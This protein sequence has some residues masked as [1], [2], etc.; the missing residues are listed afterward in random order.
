MSQKFSVSILMASWLGSLGLAHAASFEVIHSFNGPDG[1]FPIST[2]IF[3]DSGT[4]YATTSIGGSCSG[5][6]DGCGTVFSLAPNG[7][8]QVLYAFK[9]GA[10]DGDG[11]QGS[12]V[13]DADGN[14]FGITRNGGG[15]GCDLG[16]GCGTVFRLDSNGTE[17]VLHIFTGESDGGNPTDLVADS[18]GTLYGTTTYGGTRNAGTV[19]RISPKGKFKR[20]YNFSGGK[21]G[22]S[23]GGR[24]VVYSDGNLYGTTQ[25]GGNTGNCSSGCGTVFQ[26]APDGKEKVLYAFRGGA[27]D[28]YQPMAGLLLGR[29]GAFYGT[30][31]F[32]GSDSD[33]GTVF[34]LTAAGEETMLHAFNGDNGC[35]PQAGVIED[36]RGML[37]GATMHGGPSFLGTVFKLVPNG[38]THVLYTFAGEEDGCVPQATLARHKGRLYG[39]AL[40]CG[41]TF[42]GTVFR[43][44][45]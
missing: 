33:C 4:L 26:L 32:G 38:K 1:A 12:L 5:F 31:F 23:P 43:V 36:N 41:S 21:D 3:D 27:E 14:L 25:F 24:L 9:G 45:P 16:R 44:Q 11:P 13:R 37:Y 34:R 2:P 28:G 17:K 19:F 35:F 6:S 30:T 42:N 39:T 18:L 20:L 15:V 40:T 29:D 8:Q 7:D 10:T 22:G